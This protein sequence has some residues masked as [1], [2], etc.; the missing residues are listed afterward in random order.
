MTEPDRRALVV[1]H[2]HVSPTG[3]VGRRLVER[4]FELVHHLVVPAADHDGLVGWIE[5]G[6]RA[7]LVERGLDPEALVAA[8]RADE[9]GDDVARHRTARPVDAFLD[10]VARPGQPAG[11]PYTRST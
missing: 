7:T 10:R 11:V 6:G 1:A 9:A 3:H 2:D 8:M 5:N 4:G